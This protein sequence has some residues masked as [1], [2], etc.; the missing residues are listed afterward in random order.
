[1]ENLV[2]FLS[3]PIIRQLLIL[4]V[5]FYGLGI[6]EIISGKHSFQNKGIIQAFSPTRTSCYV[7]RI[8]KENHYE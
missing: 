2:N 1:M 5:T 6:A 4:D 7:Q 3:V 8:L